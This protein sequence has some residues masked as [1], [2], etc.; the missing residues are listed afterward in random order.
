MGLWER[1]AGL[2]LQVDGYELERR[3]L[4]VSSGFVRV[5]TTVRLLGPE[6][7]TGLGED[8]TY[9][10]EDHDCS[11]DDLDIEGSYTLE[12]FSDRL[13]ELSS[14]AVGATAG[15]AAPPA[16]AAPGEATALP[17]AAPAA[18]A[19]LGAAFFCA[20]PQMTS[21]YAH[22]R[23]GFESAALDLA[24][25]QQGLS[26]GVALG[27]PYRPVRFVVSTRQDIRGWLSHYPELEFKVDPVPDW[28]DALLA[29]LAATGAV[30]VVDFK[31]FYTG[32]PVDNPVDP[33]LYARVIRALP[34]VIVEDAAVRPDT[35]AALE[36]VADRLSWDAPVHS[37]ADVAGLPQPVTHL[38]IKP[39]RFGT[40]RRL[41]ECIERAQQAGIALYGGGQ[42]EL[43][44]GR[45]QI[46]ALA[47]LFYADS[48]ND[49]A[50]MGYNEPQARPGLPRSPLPVPDEQTGFSFGDR[51]EG[52]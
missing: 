6:G 49:V 36:P 11:R 19:A 39:S 30:R 18:E 10:A 17:G 22:R 37:W 35:A 33:A 8:V 32:T 45:G 13:D 34:G 3:E 41:L 9:T 43:G 16:E 42:F 2:E 48:P 50:P 38:N 26:L 28:D 23:W 29:E 1:L 4:A 40:L 51:V 7:R 24:L 25:R 52:R 12:R 14:D 20:P 46:Q 5:T 15:E 47:S 21:S 27:L 31:A 44:P